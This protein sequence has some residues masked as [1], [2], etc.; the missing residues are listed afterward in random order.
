MFQIGF[1][2]TYVTPLLFVL[3]ISFIKGMADEFQ[4]GAAVASP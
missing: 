2:V 3:L 4:R 1:L